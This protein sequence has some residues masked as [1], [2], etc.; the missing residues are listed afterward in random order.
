MMRQTRKRC[1]SLLLAVALA[2]SLAVLPVSA[3]EGGGSAPASVELR[4]SAD[5]SPYDRALVVLI[6]ENGAVA[7]AQAA[8]EEQGGETFAVYQA[9][10]PD[11]RY[12]VLSMDFR[13]PLWLLRMGSARSAATAF[14]STSSNLAPQ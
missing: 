12:F 9:Q 10:A 7:L 14:T 4:V 13:L 11:E 2:L 3:E 1:L 8:E 5:G 6:G